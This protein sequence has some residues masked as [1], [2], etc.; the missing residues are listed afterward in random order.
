[1]AFPFFSAK[2]NHFG[3]SQN[4]KSLTTLLIILSFAFNVLADIPPTNEHKPANEATCIGVMLFLTAVATL[5]IWLL[6]KKEM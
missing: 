1:M 3:R 5:G 2:I 6:K 4:M